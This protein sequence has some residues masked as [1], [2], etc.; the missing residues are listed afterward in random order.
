MKIA[1]FVPDG[2]LEQA[3]KRAAA[4]GMSRSE[5]FT[6]AAQRYLQQL[7]AES[8]TQQIDAAVTLLSADVSSRVAVAAGHRRVARNA[9]VW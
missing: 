9:D 7:D 8:V 4:L 5:F 3:T 2:T 6:S 1:I